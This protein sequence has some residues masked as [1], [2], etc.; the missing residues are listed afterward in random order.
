VCRSLWEL[1]SFAFS[2]GG[3]PG[4]PSPGLG[5]GGP[6]LALPPA[7]PPGLL[8]HG[9]LSHGHVLCVLLQPVQRGVG[10]QPD[11]AVMVLGV[12]PGNQTSQGQLSAGPEQDRLSL[13]ALVLAR[14]VC[15]S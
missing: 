6:R 1:L 13:L 7:H 10:L 12:A 2:N 4:V 11:P 5:E 8:V 9:L 3:Q 14:L 15:I